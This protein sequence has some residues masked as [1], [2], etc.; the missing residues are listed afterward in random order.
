MHLS[1]H[2][3][4]SQL[5]ACIDVY[6]E[7]K[8]YDQLHEEIGELMLEL[9]HF[10]RGRCG[11]RNVIVEL[12]DLRMMLDVLE[13]MLNID[14]VEYAEVEAQQYEKMLTQAGEFNKQNSK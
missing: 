8:Q 9:A 12:V 11:I 5:A 7:Q 2:P 6:S 13:N 3:F 4:H 14:P 10:K 1:K